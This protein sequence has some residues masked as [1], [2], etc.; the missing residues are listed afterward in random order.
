METSVVQV[1]KDDVVLYDPHFAEIQT[2]LARLASDRKKVETPKELIKTREVGGGKMARYVD[3]PVYQEALDREFP[4][5]S[6]IGEPKYWCEYGE[7]TVINEETKLPMSQKVPVV[8]NCSIILQVVEKT[9]TIR[10]VSGIGTATVAQAEMS[11]SSTQLLG[12][13]YTIA[14]T[15]AIKT[16][17]NWLGLF[18]DLRGDQEAIEESYLP[19]SDEQTKLFEDL[20]SDVPPETRDKLRK[21][22]VG[23]NRRSAENLINNIIKRKQEVASKKAQE[24]KS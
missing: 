12:Q 3:R 15:D 11:R 22:W 8:F 17:C 9:G 24:V 16:A 14:L 13:K 7:Y 5:W 10:R 4:G 19:A 21:Q 6:I 20:I 18:F 1:S 23:Q 2:E